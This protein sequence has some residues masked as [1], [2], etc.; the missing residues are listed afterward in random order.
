M[1]LALRSGD[2]GDEKGFFIYF[3]AV[4]SYSQNYSG[5]VTK[6]PIDSGSPVVDHFTR[7]NPVVTISA[8]VTGVD[9]STG[10]F[11]I[12]GVDGE[13]AQNVRQAPNAVSVQGSNNSLIDRF[14][15]SSIG[16]FL[17]SSM[18]EPLMDSAR[19][20]VVEQVRAALRELIVGVKFNEATGEEEPNINLVYL[21]EY[22]GTLLNR[23]VSNLVVTNVVFSESVDSGEGLFCDITLEQVQFVGLRSEAIPQEYT[24]S[25]QPQAAPKESQ[26]KQ[27]STVQEVEEEEAMEESEL[28]R[29]GGGKIIDLLR[30]GESNGD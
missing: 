20:S 4:T 17:P 9:V 15:P 6:H 29:L 16:Q 25:M 18:P 1:S 7:E 5:G 12:T 19:A 26:G 21:Y 24:P 14:I 10:S 3:D 2:I 23:V 22:N 13:R 27:D 30:G 11:N 8:V 28:S